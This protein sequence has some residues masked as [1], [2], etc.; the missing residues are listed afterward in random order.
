MSQTWRKAVSRVRTSAGVTKTDFFILMENTRS[1]QVLDG[2][3][4]EQHL[5]QVS[6]ASKMTLTGGNLTMAGDRWLKAGRMSNIKYLPRMCGSASLIRSGST[7]LLSQLE[8]LDVV[9]NGNLIEGWVGRCVVLK[10]GQRV[11]WIIDI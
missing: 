5:V 6:T 7:T 1:S 8:L 4:L 9:T 10:E 11:N 2:L 3:S